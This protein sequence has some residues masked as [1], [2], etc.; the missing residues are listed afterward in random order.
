MLALDDTEKKLRDEIST[1]RQKI[2]ILE[3]SN[4]PQNPA[5][6]MKNQGDNHFSDLSDMIMDGFIRTDMNG[7][8]IDV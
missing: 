7:N 4:R 2:A 5:P 3:S 6:S 8:I 1:L